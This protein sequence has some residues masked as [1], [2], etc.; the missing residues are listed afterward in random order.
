MLRDGCQAAMLRPI[1]VVLSDPIRGLETSKKS[2]SSFPEDGNYTKNIP[3]MQSLN[4]TVGIGGPEDI[5]RGQGI[6]D[7]RRME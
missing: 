3:E 6:S 1:D 4:E 5:L 2:F 7:D